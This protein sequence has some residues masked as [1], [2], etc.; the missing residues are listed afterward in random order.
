MRLL[1]ISGLAA[2]LLCSCRSA[3]TAYYAPEHPARFDP[4]PMNTQGADTTTRS[5]AALLLSLQRL[6]WKIND[7]KPNEGKIVATACLGAGHRADECQRMHFLIGPTGVVIS[8]HAPKRPII[9]KMDG[10]VIRWM[11]NLDREFSLHRCMPGDQVGAVLH[12]YGIR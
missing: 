10:H 12:Q 6:N 11:R 4:C 9:R 8:H 3:P 1:A 5:Y 2:L 7:L